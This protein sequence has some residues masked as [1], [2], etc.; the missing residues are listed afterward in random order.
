MVNKVILDCRLGAA[1][2][3]LHILCK[4]SKLFWHRLVA[5]EPVQ[6]LKVQRQVSCRLEA[7]RTRVTMLCVL[8]EARAMHEV[9]TRELLH[10]NGALKKIFMADWAVGLH[11]M[12]SACVVVEKVER[13]ACIAAH[14]MERIYSQPLASTAHV[15]KRAMVNISTCIQLTL[16]D[17]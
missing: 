4:I 14:A 13:H 2:I 16:S 15:A 1:I 7:D 5:K 11:G 10:R 6:H 12:L 8:H 3:A 17:N 9:S